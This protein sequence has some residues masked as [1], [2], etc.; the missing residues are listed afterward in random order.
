VVDLTN[1]VVILE[2]GNLTAPLMNAVLLTATNKVIDLGLTN[3]L[4][5][6]LTLSNGTFAGSVREPGLTGS[7]IFKGVLLQ[8]ENSGYGYFLEINR[9]GRVVF[10]PV[11]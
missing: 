7:N 5:L 3:K 1:G 6:S 4:S 2:G 11:P 9:S 8:N 10:R